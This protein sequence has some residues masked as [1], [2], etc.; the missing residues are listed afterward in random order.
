GRIMNSAFVATNSQAVKL[1]EDGSIDL[2]IFVDRA[3]VEVFAQGH[4]VAG[5]NQIFPDAKS[6]GLDVIVEGESAS[7]DIVLYPL[8]SIWTTSPTPPAE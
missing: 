5:A 6:L 8:K 4:T 7:A 2:H 3:S 1:N